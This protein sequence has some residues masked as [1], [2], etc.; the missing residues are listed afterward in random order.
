MARKNG[1]A[2]TTSASFR[3]RSVR[4]TVSKM[5]FSAGLQSIEP[6]SERLGFLFHFL[7]RRRGIRLWGF[8]SNPIEAISDSKSRSNSSRFEPNSTERTRAGGI[9]AGPVKACV[10]QAALRVAAPERLTRKVRA[11]GGNRNSSRTTVFRQWGDG[12]GAGQ[13]GPAIADEWPPYS[14]WDHTTHGRQLARGEIGRNASRDAVGTPLA[15]AWRLFS[16]ARPVAR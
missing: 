9:A 5:A 12:D 1:S 10:T 8:T 13:V 3:C 11:S 4:K 15:P 16:R 6:Q 2:L 14:A 7:R